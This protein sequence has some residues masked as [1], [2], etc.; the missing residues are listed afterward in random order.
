MSESYCSY[1][2]IHAGIGRSTFIFAQQTVERERERGMNLVF[3]VKST[4]GL[5]ANLESTGDTLT[6]P[7]SQFLN[8]T[9][10]HMLTAHCKQYRRQRT[11]R[12][13]EPAD[14]VP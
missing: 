12:T 3:S 14:A 4:S 13:I 8:S 5:E 6:P 2:D 10:L 7:T 1:F 11:S 9:V